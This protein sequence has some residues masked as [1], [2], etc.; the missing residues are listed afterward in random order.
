MKFLHRVTRKSDGGLVDEFYN[1]DPFAV[2]RPGCRV[3]VQAVH[4]SVARLQDAIL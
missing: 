1:D 4:P 2:I 3:R